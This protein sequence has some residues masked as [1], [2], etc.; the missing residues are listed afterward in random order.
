[1]ED[2]AIL[3]DFNCSSAAVVVVVIVSIHPYV[4]GK[5]K[6]RTETRHE[7]TF[8]PTTNHRHYHHLYWKKSRNSTHSRRISHQNNCSKCVLYDAVPHTYLLY[9]SGT[10]VKYLILRMK[11]SRRRKIKVHQKSLLRFMCNFGVLFHFERSRNA[12]TF[13]ASSEEDHLMNMQLCVG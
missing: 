1:M 12:N 10:L 7:W 13:S 9:K 2:M 5:I 6:M 3:S 4:V 11:A 8:G